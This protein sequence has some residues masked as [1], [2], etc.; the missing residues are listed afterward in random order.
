MLKSSAHYTT[1]A[2]FRDAAAIPNSLPPE[3]LAGMPATY[4]SRHPIHPLH[5]HGG[6]QGNSHPKFPYHSA[7][8][9]DGQFG[10]PCRNRQDHFGARERNFFPTI[11]PMAIYNT[12]P[13]NQSSG[14]SHRNTIELRKQT[15]FNSRGKVSKKP[16]NNGKFFG[17]LYCQFKTFSYL[18]SRKQTKLLTLN[19]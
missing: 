19:Y 2:P 10:C 16:K 17:F 5:G 18:C 14:D 11:V 3:S 15:S 7:G 9:M 1:Q 4:S 12:H 8:F 13:I 6:F